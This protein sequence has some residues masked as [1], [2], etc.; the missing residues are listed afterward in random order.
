[1]QP[2]LTG[3]YPTLV[4]LGSGFGYYSELLRKHADYLV[5]LDAFTPALQM[6]RER[7]GYDDLIRADIM[8]LPLRS[9]GIDCVTLFDVIEHLSK[10]EGRVLLRTLEPSVFVS[11]PNSAISNRIYARI[12]GNILENHVSAWSLEEFED[13]GYEAETQTPPFW[14]SLLGNK[15]VLCACRPRPNEAIDRAA[16]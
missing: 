14:M 9:D 10:D 3:T 5:G 6:A 4:D 15:G 13:M 2:I 7:K 16:N 11:T 1:M 8:H 12:L